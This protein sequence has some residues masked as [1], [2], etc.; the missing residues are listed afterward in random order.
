MILNKGTATMLRPLLATATLVF[1]GIAAAP[2]FADFKV[3]QPYVDYGEL[4]IEHK[5]FATQG[6]GA[7]VRNNQD[8]IGELF[9]GVTPWWG[10]G[11]EG[12][13]ERDPGPGNPTRFQSYAWENRFQFTEQG[14]YWA[15][16]GFFTELEHVP[17]KTSADQLTFG[18]IVAK[19][20]GP[21]LNTLDFFLLKELGAGSNKDFQLNYRWQTR[22]EVNPWLEP[23]FE[24]HGVPGAINR[25]TGLQNQDHRAG[26]VLYGTIPFGRAG[27]L[28][29]ELGY[30]FGLT[31]ATPTGTLKWTLEYEISF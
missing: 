1:A 4:E 16:F 6:G 22:L 19:E 21:T 27:E 11:V 12:E 7:G 18:P 9:Y 31:R 13:W 3:Q 24:I 26:P 10:T 8:Y 2:A 20:I 30:L 5:G 14:K 25:F 15:D 29:Y 23:G 28:K 17:R